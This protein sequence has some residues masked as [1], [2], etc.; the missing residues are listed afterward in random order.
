VIYVNGFDPLAGNDLGLTL[1]EVWDE[2]DMMPLLGVWRSPGGRRWIVVAVS[3][4]INEGYVSDSWLAAPLTDSLYDAVVAD[5]VSLRDAFLA[6]GSAALITVTTGPDRRL[7]PV[8]TVSMDAAAV[9]VEYLPVQG[10]TLHR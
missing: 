2:Y 9:P 4:D 1:D 8:Q 6:D 7:F 10:V 3:S 5:A